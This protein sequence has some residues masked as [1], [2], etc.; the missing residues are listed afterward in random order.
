[1][2]DFNGRALDCDDCEGERGKRGKRGHRG[3]DGHDGVAGATGATGPTG[4][5]GPTGTTGPGGATALFVFNPFG[6][7]SDNLFTT[8]TPLVA[9]M[10]AVSGAK[11]LQ[12]DNTRHANGTS[13]TVPVAGTVRIVSEEPIFTPAMVGQN[14]YIQGAAIPP[15][16]G[17][18]PV[19]SFIDPSTLEYTNAAGVAEPGFIGSWVVV[20]S[21]GTLNVVIPAGVWDMT[22]VEWIGYHNPL[23]VAG[24]GGIPVIVSDGASFENLRKIDGDV[25][26]TNLNNLPNPAP[27]AMRAAGIFEFGTGPAGDFPQII[28]NGTAPFFD[29][30]AMPAGQAMTIRMAGPMRGS[31]RVVE[32]GA[33][34]GS[35][36]FS[37]FAPA[38]VAVGM[39]AGTNPA[40]VMSIAVQDNSIYFGQQPAWAGT[41]SFNGF[42]RFQTKF[43]P[44]M[45]AGGVATPPSAVAF[46][47]GTGLAMNTTLRF[48]TT[49]GNVAQTLPQIKVS[50][51]VTG[52]TSLADG[53]LV[54]E[55][56]IVVLKNQIGANNV[57][58]APAAGNTIEGGAGPLVIPAG[59]SRILQS[60]GVSNWIV[61]A[62]A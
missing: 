56:M 39:V 50:V 27:V 57:N 19:S 11:Q 62:A 34:A 60:D 8:W 13:L 25:I 21:G 26:V 32:M 2:A 54:S 12:F 15:N 33:A 28:N 40:S 53:S 61:I 7:P 18:F 37:L 42:T 31:S 10:Q 1:M 20:G 29:G 49:A 38:S 41:L 44:G 14:I 22:Q 58:V 30:T 23:A 51:P 5:T 6:V 46:T 24:A 9:A 52:S 43:L 3:H 45:G 35:L 59:G 47:S 36:I 55:A 17:A 16:N 4:P 48:D